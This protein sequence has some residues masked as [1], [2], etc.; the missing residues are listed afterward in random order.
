MASSRALVGGVLGVPVGFGIDY[1]W[2]AFRLPGYGQIVAPIGHRASG[3][4]VY[5]GVDDLLE[6]GVGGLLAIVGARS[7]NPTLTGLGVGAAVGVV[8]TKIFETM[9]V[10]VVPAACGSKVTLPDFTTC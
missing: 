3:A 2:S 7:K 8:A 1:V 4:T 5:L 9:G 10:A 6:I